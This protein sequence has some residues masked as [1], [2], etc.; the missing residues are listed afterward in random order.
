VQLRLESHEQIKR[1]LA[2]VTP[3]DMRL[4]E[5][6]LEEAFLRLSEAP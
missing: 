2:E 4:K 3:L 6:T 1:V 5:P